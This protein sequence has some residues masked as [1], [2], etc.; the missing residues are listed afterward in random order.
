MIALRYLDSAFDDV[1]EITSRLE[2]EHAGFGASFA[3]LFDAMIEKIKATPR[4]FGR[5]EDGL[6]GIETREC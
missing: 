6:R 3:E 2:S 1:R 4:F 5:T